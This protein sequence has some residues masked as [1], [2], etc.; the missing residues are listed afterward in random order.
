[1]VTIEMLDGAVHLLDTL[2]DTRQS[3]VCSSGYVLHDRLLYTTH[4]ITK[5]Y[6]IPSPEVAGW[7][8]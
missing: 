1:M 3:R 6:T 5:T 7:H 2:V 8:P 4:Y